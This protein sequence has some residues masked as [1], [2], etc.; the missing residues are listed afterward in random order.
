MKNR[1]QDL[2]VCGLII[3]LTGVAIKLGLDNFAFIVALAFFFGSIAVSIIDTF[4]D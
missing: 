1:A 2:F 4:E 3:L